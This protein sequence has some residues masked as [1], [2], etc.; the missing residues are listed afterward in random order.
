MKGE[1]FTEQECFNN[2]L[3]YAMQHDDYQFAATKILNNYYCKDR[4]CDGLIVPLSFTSDH[5]R[6][7]DGLYS[8]NISI[9]YWT[10]KHAELMRKALVDE[11]IPLRAA[12]GRGRFGFLDGGRISSAIALEMLGYWPALPEFREVILHD[13]DDMMRYTCVY[14]FGEMKDR[15]MPYKKDIRESIR[16]FKGEPCYQGTAIKALVQ[17]KD[18]DAVPLLCDLF[19][20]AVDFIHRLPEDRMTDDHGYLS[21]LTDIVEALAVLD[22]KRAREILA[23]GMLDDNPHIQYFTLRSFHLRKDRWIME[24]MKSN[25]QLLV[26]ALPQNPQRILLRQR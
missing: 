20:E 18:T 22:P 16:K 3:E 24:A 11:S 9:L 13:L 21:L 26:E 25:N 19:E 4:E 12:D 10:F 2:A 5:W 15:A 14:A 23:T 17:L 6:W 8:Q 7:H 1:I